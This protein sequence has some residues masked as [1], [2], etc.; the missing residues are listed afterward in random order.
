MIRLEQL[1]LK[2]SSFSLEGISFQVEEGEFFALIGPTGSGKTLILESIAGLIKPTSGRIFLAGRDVTGLDP[3]QRGVGIV[4]Q[5]HA[6]FP[7]LN[8]RK[9]ITYG[10]R[11][12]AKGSA[13]AA[14]K[15][16]LTLCERLGISHLLDR[17]VANLSGGEKQRVSLARALS[18][19]PRV[20]LLDEPLSALDPNFRG[21]I[22]DM[23]A[24]LHHETGLTCLMVSHDF[25]EVRSLAGRAAVI[26][27]GR[28][29]QTGTVE[30]IF[31]RPGSKFVARFVGVKNLFAA[32]CREGRVE[33]GPVSLELC[34]ANGGGEGYVCIRPETVHPVTGDA[35]PAN[36]FA[37]SVRSLMDMGAYWEA[38]LQAGEIK[39]YCHLP[40]G[41]E[42]EEGVK[43]GRGRYRIDPGDIHFLA[44]KA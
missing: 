9:N 24:D 37:A 21:E 38:Q 33:L 6:L 43:A 7:H 32:T 4:Y 14:E 31:L 12:L 35:S 16:V 8:V 22:R 27:K 30:E 42:G 13:A 17:G 34:R 2:L 3:E 26:R 40:K 41:A 10:L 39:L 44:A 19:K 15:E 23:L 1:S 28:L 5:D 20:L 36:S 18:V 11:Y 29:V 25:S